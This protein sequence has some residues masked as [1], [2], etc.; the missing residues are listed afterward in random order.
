MDIFYK[1]IVGVVLGVLIA[2]FLLN[3]R[4]RAIKKALKEHQK[5]M[6]PINW[7]YILNPKRELH[8]LGKPIIDWILYF[9][10]RFKK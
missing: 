5:N 3:R 7:D 4:N 8:Y 2:L 9:I 6:N 1:F 10:D